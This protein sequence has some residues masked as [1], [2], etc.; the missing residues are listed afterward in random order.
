[1]RWDKQQALVV[2][3]SM[4]KALLQSVSLL[5]DAVHIDDEVLRENR[6]DWLNRPPCRSGMNLAQV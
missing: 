2:Y 5:R 6:E 1:M 4:G 3:G